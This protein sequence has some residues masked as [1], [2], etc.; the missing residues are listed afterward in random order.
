MI[1]RLDTLSVSGNDSGDLNFVHLCNVYVYLKRVRK[2]LPTKTYSC[3]CSSSRVKRKRFGATHLSALIY[4]INTPSGQVEI[5]K[6]EIIIDIT[7]Q[8]DQNLCCNSENCTGWRETPI[9]GGYKSL[10]T[11]MT[12]NSLMF[13]KIRLEAPELITPA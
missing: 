5:P 11:F 1:F 4:L 7:E 9:V 6:I 8:S 3:L 10:K 13:I 12:S 2:R